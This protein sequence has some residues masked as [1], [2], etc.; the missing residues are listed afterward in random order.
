M[1]QKF[2]MNKKGG[3]PISVALIVIFTILLFATSLVSFVLRDKNFDSTVYSTSAL[4]DVYSR[5]AVIN[6]QIQN[7]VDN[8]FKGIKSKE[9][10]INNFKVQLNSLKNSEGEYLNPD[11]SQIESQLAVD[12]VKIE[13]ENDII[14]K[15]SIILDINLKKELFVKDKKVLD[16]EYNY[17]KTFES[18]S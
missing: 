12:K 4:D 3:V 10:F 15:V 13:K 16:A 11:L 18:K 14:K 1:N 9:D 17:A 7:M 6:F 5:E 2:M 8:S